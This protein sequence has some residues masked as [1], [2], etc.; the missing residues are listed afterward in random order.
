MSAQQLNEF[1]FQL[2][3]SD[4]EYSKSNNRERKGEKYK[5]SPLITDLLMDMAKSG[6]L[7]DGKKLHKVYV[8][9]GAR[10][11]AKFVNAMM[12]VE[13]LWTE[14]EVSFV[15]WPRCSVMHC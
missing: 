3:E 6:M 2:E 4:D 11:K 9:V 7:V 10:D 12:L 5:K 1:Q 14:E 15:F 13:E 8:D